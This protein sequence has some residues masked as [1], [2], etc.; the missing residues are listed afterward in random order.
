VIMGVPHERQ[1]RQFR[2]ITA[3][4]HKLIGGEEVQERQLR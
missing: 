1:T 4:D 3:V 2:C